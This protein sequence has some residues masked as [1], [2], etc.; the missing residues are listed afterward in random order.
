MST[1][2]SSSPAES[3]AATAVADASQATVARKVRDLWELVKP[4]ISFLV[5]VSAL[6]G[7]LLGSPGVIDP[8]VLIATLLGVFASAGGAG[9]FNHIVERHLDARMKRTMQRPLPANRISLSG[10]V[11]FGGTLLVV[12]LATL[13]LLVNTLTAGLAA[14]TAGLYV[15]LYT[16]L[17]QRSKLNT[18]VGTI[19]GALPALGGW[20]AATGAL[21]WGGWALFG[22][23]LCW[24]M[25][26][27][28]SLAW[29]YRKDYAR[30]GY[31]MLPVVEPDG[32]STAGQTLFFTI[33]LL[34]VSLT[35]LPLG[36]AGWVYTAGALLLGLWFCRKAYAF[37]LDLTPQKARQVLMASIVYIPALVALIFVDWLI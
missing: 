29:M 36:V 19:P 8:G 34:G 21:G 16:P 37:Y 32:A 10:A 9:V 7:F 27:F 2:R 22:V 35:L 23:L 31:V 28:L 14:L 1:D 26:H 20:T 17:K 11:L 33:L 3:S 5:T 25:P 6:A 30:A 24:Q 13:Y 18:L 15:L 12:G 4:E